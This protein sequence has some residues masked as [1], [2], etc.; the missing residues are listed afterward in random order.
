MSTSTE[1]QDL[2]VDDTGHANDVQTANFDNVGVL[3]ASWF[4][5]AAKDLFPTSAREDIPVLNS[6]TSEPL[7]VIY[8]PASSLRFGDVPQKLISSSSDKRCF[9]EVDTTQD[10]VEDL[11]TCLDQ[12]I[13]STKKR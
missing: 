3:V 9:I 5:P 12:E 7:P 1:F 2:F 8:S 10:E 6:T 4:S 11:Q 13:T